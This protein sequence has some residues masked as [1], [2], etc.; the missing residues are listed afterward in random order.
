MDK[1]LRQSSDD[2]KQVIADHNDSKALGVQLPADP[3]A[4]L[5]SQERARIVRTLEV[6][7]G[8]ADHDSRTA[9][10]SGSSI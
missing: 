7:T 2:E 9:V 10:F 5:S 3:D 6:L 8:Q 1:G 4:H